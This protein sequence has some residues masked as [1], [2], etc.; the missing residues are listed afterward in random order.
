MREILELRTSEEEAKRHLPPG[1][2]ERL[3]HVRRLRLDVKDPLVEKLKAI[4][5]EYR[6]RGTTLFSMCA[7]SR[8]Y[9]PRELEAA[10]YLKV[11]LWPY[12]RPTGEEC[13]TAY[14]EST[15]CSHCGAGA[16]QVNEL[17]L[18]LSRIPRSR[19][20]SLTLGG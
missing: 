4:E 3:G 19:D 10:E 11:E 8:L 5:A 15:A 6:A 17:H 2:G 20:L 1:V 13:G 12:F 9:T 18:E 16:R 7:V 14:D